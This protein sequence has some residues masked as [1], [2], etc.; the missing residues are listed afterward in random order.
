MILKL[1]IVGVLCALTSLA[2][3]MGRAVF[4]DG[5]R[6][7]MPEYVEG[8]M[9]RGEMASVAFGL[10]AGFVF[11]VGFAFTLASKLLNPWLLFLPTDIL[12]VIAPRKWI[13]AVLGAA[14]GVGVTAAFSA[15]NTVFSLLPINFLNSLGQ[16]SSP[17]LAGFALFPVLAIFYQFGK[18]KGIITLILE[19]I[20]RQLAAMNYITIHGTPITPEALEMFVGVVLLVTFAV[21]K[22]L[23]N[24]EPRT[25]DDGEG[26]FEVRTK[27]IVKSIPL[28]MAIG[29]LVSLIANLQ[30]FAGS[31]VD[32]Q[33]LHQIY[34]T[35]NTSEL[36]TVAFADFIR[37]LAFIPLIVTTALAS[38]VY[39]IVGLTFVYPIGFYVA[40]AIFGEGMAGHIAAFVFGAVWLAIEMFVLRVIG[41]GLENFPSLREASDSIRNAMNNVLE[42]ALLIGS[43]LAALSMTHSPKDPQ[44]FFAFGIFVALY[45]IN[46]AIGRPVIRLAAAPLAAIITGVVVNIFYVAHLM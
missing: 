38:G 35:H 39:G 32:F 3:H 5:I 9:K 15:L 33:A 22:D 27:R 30:Y 23:R 31:E 25:D 42:Y 4:H 11:S 28:M 41:K 13:A 10:S 44:N 6:P 12:G 17:V 26:L 34:T 18:V 2:S 7:I 43:A 21:V 8:R 19:L 37:G 45:A 14:W 29:G 1:I 40:P 16:L 46:E 36:S 24:K 20:V